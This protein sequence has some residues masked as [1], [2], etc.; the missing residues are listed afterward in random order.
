[1]PHSIRAI[2]RSRKEIGGQ[3]VTP[4][5]CGKYSASGRNPV[6]FPL[7]AEI[8]GKNDGRVE[9]FSR[10]DAVSSP[11]RLVIP[12][13]SC[14]SSTVLRFIIVADTSARARR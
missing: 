7:K 8:S 1:M 9:D 11:T 14:E 4:V 12:C 5:T 10:F 2:R 3:S 13:E 6:M